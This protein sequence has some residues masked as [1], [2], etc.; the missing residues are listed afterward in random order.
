MSDSGKKPR[1]WR[2]RVEHILSAVEEIFLY[3]KNLSCDDFLGDDKTKRAVERCFEIIG[4]AAKHIPADVR[5][6]TAQIPWRRVIAYRNV[7]AHDYDKSRDMMMWLTIQNELP[8]LV[9]VLRE[10]KNTVEKE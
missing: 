2:I 6:R 4:E 9:E 3:T 10:M 5:D 1:D 7:L 8:D